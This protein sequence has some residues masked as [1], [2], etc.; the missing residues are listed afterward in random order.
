V[1]LLTRLT[2]LAGSRLLVSAH[3]LSGL[4]V[5]DVP[6]FMRQDVEAAVPAASFAHVVWLRRVGT[7][8]RQIVQGVLTF[9]KAGDRR[10]TL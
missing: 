1:L 9:K 6:G 4:E 2:L 3:A 7:F 5:P 8:L 10:E